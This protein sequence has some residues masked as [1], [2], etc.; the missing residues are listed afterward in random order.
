MA[1][2]LGDGG[3][4]GEEVTADALRRVHLAGDPFASIRWDR[5]PTFL[6]LAAASRIA[7]GTQV[8]RHN[9][10]RPGQ[11]VLTEF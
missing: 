1:A 3:A 6:R 10:W 8:S 2:E 9:S 11:F 5:G 7:Q 4:A